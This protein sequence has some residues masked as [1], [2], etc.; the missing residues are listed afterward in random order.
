VE[1]NLFRALM[2]YIDVDEVGAGLDDNRSWADKFDVL[3]GEILSGNS[4]AIVNHQMR[5]MLRH[6]LMIGRFSRRDY[7]NF[8]DQFHL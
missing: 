2:K 4:S 5:E 7:S 1:Q 3:R 8:I 6:G